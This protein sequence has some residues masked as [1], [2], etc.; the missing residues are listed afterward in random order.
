[1]P[2]E[3]WV[4]D[5]LV[6]EPDCTIGT[7]TVDVIGNYPETLEPVDSLAVFSDLEAR[8]TWNLYVEDIGENDAGTLQAWGV[9]LTCL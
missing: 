8:G 5:S 1:M 7:I 4:E 6:I 9:N 2:D 3:E